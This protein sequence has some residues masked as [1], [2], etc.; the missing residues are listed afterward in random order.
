[1]I[2]KEITFSKEVIKGNARLIVLFLLISLPF[3]LILLFLLCGWDVK[4]ILSV[5]GFTYLFVSSLLTFEILL[6]ARK[7]RNTKLQLSEDKLIKLEGKKN[8]SLLWQEISRIK[9]LKRKCG[10]IHKIIIGLSS[11]KSL[12]LYGFEDMSNLINL[13]EEKVSDSTSWRTKTLFLTR[14]RAI[15]LAVLLWLILLM[16]IYLLKVHTNLL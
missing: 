12:A 8:T 2:M 6:G 11:G 7:Q 4:E 15:C 1:M 5:T 16:L 14:I 3:I 10:E 9:V 13:I